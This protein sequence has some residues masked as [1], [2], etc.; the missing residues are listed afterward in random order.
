MSAFMSD[1]IIAVSDIHGYYQEFVELMKKVNYQKGRDKL[2]I[3]GDMIDRGP[4]SLKVITLIRNL[5]LNYPETVKVIRGNH[6]DEFI[7]IARTLYK[8]ENY[9]ED[10]WRMYAGFTGDDLTGL[11]I[12]NEML[13]QN[14]K[15]LLLKWLEG[16]PLYIEDGAYVFV[17]AGVNPKKDIKNQNSQILLWGKGNNEMKKLFVWEPCWQDKVVVFG[18]CS[19]DTFYSRVEGYNCNDIW[20]DMNN[21]DKIGID[22][23]VWKNG[24]LGALIINN[25]YSDNP[26]HSEI[27][28]DTNKDN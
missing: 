14:D 26:Q 2:Y 25:P 21:R 1:R 4:E 3:L 11:Q 17:H 12:Y 5:Q 19:T 16:L 24:K 7:K 18:H 13:N 15:D 22:C 9:D 23:G 8:G 28:I 20:Y 27:Y 6:D 10:S